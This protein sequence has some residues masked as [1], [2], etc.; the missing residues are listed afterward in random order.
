MDGFERE[1]DCFADGPA[2]GARPIHAV[3]PEALPALLAQL[4]A[5]QAAYLAGCP[6]RARAGEVVLLPGEAG[7]AGAVLG[8]GGGHG[9]HVWGALPPKLPEG[10]PWCL[11]T[12]DGDPHEAVLGWALGAY[13]FDR[14][15]SVAAPGAPVLVLPD[16]PGVGRA[17]SAARATW[18]ARDLV[19]MPA[20]L[21]GPAEL[22]AI[23]CETMTRAG[24]HADVITGAALAERYPVLQAV[25][26]GSARAPA[27][28][29]AQWRGPDAGAHAALVSLC[30]KGVCFDS[31]GYDL[32]P[33]SGML[34]MK[35]DM[36]GAAIALGLA[37]MI[38]DAALPVR[39]ELRLGCV[40]NM[41]SG[42][43][44]RP[45][46]L[47]KTREG[48]AIEV[49][50]TD[51]EGRLVLCE[52]L[53]EAC[54]SK[55]YALLDFAT[56]T[57]AARVALGPDLPALFSN[58]DVLANVFVASGNAT[59]D[60][61]WRLPLWDGYNSWLDGGAGDMNNVS[62]K[63]HAGAIVAALFLQR[64]VSAGTSWAHFDV[65]AWNDAG[66]IG[67]PAGGEAQAM[68]AAFAGLE[69]FVSSRFAG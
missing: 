17:L 46:D 62:E 41:I 10:A 23:A 50:N 27:V 22:A 48:V 36:G 34:R 30:G 21:L 69:A 26:R 61:V 56:L 7:V 38:I 9:P 55:P 37:R 24:A 18:L 52:L 53:S 32:K 16:W 13:R 3:R 25:G 66:R 8:L 57:G 2:T 33:P 51:A 35:K 64:F 40:E 65:Y 29:L 28:V 1:L 31:G 44:M 68:R 42:D 20:N 11:D 15:R 58:D 43:A 59:A 63:A 54:A 67:R 39:L 19:N 6:F 5:G 49:G 47:L 12:P 14:L 60:P 4:P 45:L